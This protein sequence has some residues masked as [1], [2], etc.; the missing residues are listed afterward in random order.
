[1]GSENK[2]ENKEAK[3][4]VM[5]ISKYARY[6]L[7]LITFIFLPWLLILILIYLLQKQDML[8]KKA[9]EQVKHW[10]GIAKFLS[11]HIKETS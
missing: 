8:T 2:R 6:L 10:E 3:A 11:E 5:S 9:Q 1:M 4:S 7:L